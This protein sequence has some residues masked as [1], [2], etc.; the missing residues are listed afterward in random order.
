MH[1]R[2]KMSDAVRL[3]LSITTGAALMAPVGVMAQSSDDGVG[4]VE[5]VMVTGS[6]IKRSTG[7]QSQEVVMITAEDMEI[8]GDVSVAD[9][10]RYSNLNSIGSFN[11]GML[12]AF[13]LA[14]F[15][16]F[17]LCCFYRVI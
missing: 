9:A 15:L 14:P 7:N 5:E 8:T 10:L 13:T 2:S 3:A 11:H 16:R 17:S 1:R 6:R 4:D 12:E